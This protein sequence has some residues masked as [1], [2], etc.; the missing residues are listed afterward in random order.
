MN[1]QPDTNPAIW[2]VLA[3]KGAQGPAGAGTGDMVR[4]NNLSDVASVTQSRINL[5]LGSSATLNVGTTANTVAAGNDARI[6]GAVQHTG[7]TMVGHLGLPVGP[8]AAQ[9]VRKD[10][11]DTADAALSTAISGKADAAAI[12][13]AATAAEYL[14]N[15]AP[16]KMLTPGA[17]WAA[18]AAVTLTDAATVTPDLSL[19]LDFIWV[20]GAVGRTLAN[21]INTKPG[22]KGI[23]YLIPS[24]GGTI[25]TWGN[26]YLFPG[27]IKPTLTGTSLLS[28][29][30]DNGGNMYCVASTGFA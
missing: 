6:D 4:A 7:D 15:S 27:G 1:K 13:A 3:A 26:K 18:A 11:V 8:G 30:I 28:Y 17:A 19:G 9:A 25:G 22:Q 24:G 20:I 23:I 14:A 21:P 16:T 12:P 10:Y 2:D 5:G 29:L